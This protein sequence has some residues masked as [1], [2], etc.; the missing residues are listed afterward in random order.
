M[1]HRRPRMAER[2]SFSDN[3]AQDMALGKSC[4]LA[5]TRS[6]AS[7]RSSS[8]GMKNVKIWVHDGIPFFYINIL[9]LNLN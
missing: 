7:R 8:C 2:P 3:S 1:Y 9:L 4:L 6:T 5:K